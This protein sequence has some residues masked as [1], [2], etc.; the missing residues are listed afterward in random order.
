MHIFY[1]IY[2]QLCVSIPQ[3]LSDSVAKA[4]PLVVG[5]EASETAKFV[6]L[7]D[8]FFDILNV[9]NFTSGTRNRKPF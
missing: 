7:F 6:S 2:M 9:S 4:R 1:K 5:D 3:V 8:N